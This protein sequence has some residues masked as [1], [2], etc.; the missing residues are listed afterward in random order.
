M[1]SRKATGWRGALCPCWQ[2]DNIYMKMKIKISVSILSTLTLLAVPLFVNAA[3]HSAGTNIIENGTV[4]MITADG[5]KRPYTSAGAFLSYG[6]NS[7]G[8]VEQANAD[9]LALP[10]GSFIPPRDGKIICSDRGIDKSTCYLISNSKRAGFV[11][12]SVFKTLGFDF[13]KVLYG[14]VSFLEKDGDISSTSEAHRAGVLVNKSGTVYIVGDNGLYGIP[15]VKTL[16]SWGYSVQDAISANTQDQQLQQAS[17]ISTR[18]AGQLKAHNATEANNS[19]IPYNFSPNNS[20]TTTSQNNQTI[21]QPQQTTN[22]LTTTIPTQPATN[23]TGANTSQSTTT[24]PSITLTLTNKTITDTTAKIE[25]QTNQPT[26]SKLYLSG[27]GLNSK[28]YTSE[29]GYTTSHFV[30]ISGL[31]ATTNYSYQITA[32]GNAGF[33]ELY[34]GFN[35]QTPTAHFL[36]YKIDKPEIINLPLVSGQTMAV[37]D[38]ESTNNSA[39]DV[40]ISQ[41]S[42]LVSI[43]KFKIHLPAKI[44]TNKS[45]QFNVAFWSNALSKNGDKSY[46][47]NQSW[48]SNLY[49]QIYGQRKLINPE[50]NY[51]AF[52]TTGYIN[53]PIPNT[54]LN[55]LGFN[56]YFLIEQSTDIEFELLLETQCKN[57]NVVCKDSSNIALDY[58]NNADLQPKL[59]VSFQALN[60]DE[61]ENKYVNISVDTV[62]N[63]NDPNGNWQ[64]GIVMPGRPIILKIQ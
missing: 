43:G 30:N 5:Q 51:Y 16:E 58:L 25:W 35:T 31:T 64:A 40:P 60:Y 12:E 47:I 18:Q 15:S 34:G 10:T 45:I 42:N 54:V 8:K 28:L 62:L 20:P 7:W 46:A 6:F 49:L 61:S 21:Q 29:A 41:N 33:I 3:P 22:P 26:E 55:K 1:G 48:M 59:G 23:N 19:P 32:I 52:A 37:M 53:L 38:I 63:A 56:N 36:K 17:V 4:F 9:D 13:S 11:S 50:P 57:Y 39:V 44:Y 14:D 24:T 2:K 27:G